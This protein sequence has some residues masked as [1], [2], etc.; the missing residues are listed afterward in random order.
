MAGKMFDQLR[1]GPLQYRPLQHS[2]LNIFMSANAFHHINRFFESY[3]AA[4]ESFDT[5]QM[6]RHFDLPCMMLSD[7]T[8]TSFTDASRLE[9]LFNQGAHFYQQY[10][11][12]HARP[13]VWSKRQWSPRIAKVRVEWRY[14]DKNNQFLYACDYQYVLHLHNQADWKIRLMVSVN[15]KERMEAWL[16]NRGNTS[17]Q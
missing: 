7:D 11:V 14:Y 6:A 1:C 3:A 15:E 2:T 8:A 16:K 12:A 4:L 17:L 10:G 9:G 5:K 13:E